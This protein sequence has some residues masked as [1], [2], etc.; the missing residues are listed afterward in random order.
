MALVGRTLTL[1]PT[2]PT[3]TGRFVKHPTQHSAPFFGRSGRFHNWRYDGRQESRPTGREIS[4]GERRCV[5][6]TY[7]GVLHGFGVTLLLMLLLLFL[8]LL[9][10]ALLI[11]FLDADSE[12]SRVRVLP[13]GG[14]VSHAAWCAS[15]AVVA[16]FAR[17]SGSKGNIHT[18]RFCARTCLAPLPS[19]RFCFIPPQLTCRTAF[20]PG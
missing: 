19:C 9:L 1:G 13:L 16:D 5:H 12:P 18:T 4:G 3:A 6:T 14:G 2:I 8:L 7:C 17:P 15:P 11:S 20:V 10:L